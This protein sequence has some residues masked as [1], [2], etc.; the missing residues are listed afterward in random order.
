MDRTTFAKGLF[1]LSAAYPQSRAE[2]GSDE[3]LEVWYTMLEDLD[4]DKFLSGIKRIIRSNKFLPSISEIRDE[5]LGKTAV[6]LEEKALQ[7]WSLVLDGIRHAGYVR[8]VRFEDPVIHNTVQSLGGWVGLCGLPS[9]TEL[10]FYR[11]SFLKAYQGFCRLALDGTLP[12]IDYLVGTN[13]LEN[14]LK[15]PELVKEPKQIG[16]QP[17]AA[18]LSIQ[19]QD[20]RGM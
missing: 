12:E 10:K 3:T 14:Q 16:I 8:S 18:L 2:L 4:G 17:G 7:A 15:F 20:Y 1:A 6:S 11:L 13:E 5:V 9:E 19:K